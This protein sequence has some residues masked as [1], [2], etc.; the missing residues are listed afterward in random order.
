MHCNQQCHQTYSA[1]GQHRSG[2]STAEPQAPNRPEGSLMRAMSQPE[3]LVGDDS[4]VG[5][6]QFCNKKM[7]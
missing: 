7:C 4:L 6:F 3:C 1:G 5:Q 2:R